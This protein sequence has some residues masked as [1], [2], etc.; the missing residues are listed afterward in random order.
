MPDVLRAALRAGAS[1]PADAA[2]SGT[3]R[4][5]GAATREGA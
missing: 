4:A 1:G 2:T 5:C 3:Q